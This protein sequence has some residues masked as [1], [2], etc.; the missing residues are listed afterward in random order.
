VVSADERNVFDQRRLEYELL[1][2][3]RPDHFCGLDNNLIDVNEKK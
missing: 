3:L 2:K 1:D